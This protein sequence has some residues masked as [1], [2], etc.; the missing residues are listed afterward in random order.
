MIGVVVNSVAVIIGSLV[1]LLFRKG[2]PKKFSDSIMTG[3]ALCVVYI[4]ISN[5]IKGGT[6]DLALIFGMVIGAICGTVLNISGNL[7]RLG[8]WA[9][10]AFPD[11]NGKTSIAE[12]FVTAGLLFCVGAM[13]VTGSISAGQGDSSILF[14]KSVLDMI[15]ASMLTVSLG[16]GVMLSS[17]LLFIYQGSIALLSG[18]ISTYLTEE[19][20][21]TMICAGGLLIVALGL[22]MLGITKIKVADYLPALLFAPLACLLFGFVM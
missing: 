10:S 18:V 17:I 20:S 7:E 3:V 22:N 12:G 21:A 8:E 11:K 2:L 4:G 6:N 5:V 13:A 1:G 9:E 16:I 19:M 14:T 15:S